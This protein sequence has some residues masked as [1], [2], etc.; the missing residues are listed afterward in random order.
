MSAIICGS[1]A[2]DNIMVFPDHFKNHILPDKNTYFKRI[3][4]STRDATRVR[5]VRR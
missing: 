3:I 1:F 4:S 2:Y 5:W